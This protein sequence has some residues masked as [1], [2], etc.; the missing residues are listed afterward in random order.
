MAEMVASAVVGET[1]SRVSTLLIDKHDQKSS[2]RDDMERLE[3]AHIRMEAALE[4]SSNWPVVT[5]ISLL[6]WRNKL[7]RAAEECDIVLHRCKRRAMEDQE[8]EQK[9]RQCQFPKRI[10]HA[11]KSFFSSFAGHKSNELISSLT[12]QRFE[13]F[14]DGAG[15]FLKFMEFGS[16]R[17]PNYMPLDPLLG[18]LLAGKALQYDMSQGSQYYLAARPMHFAERGLEAGVLLRYQDHEMP[19]KNFTFGIL[20]RVSESMDLTGIVAKCLESFT[21]HFKP[22]V[23]SA[24]QELTR[25][26]TRGLYCFPFV[27]STTDPEY[28]QIHSSETRRARPNP[29]CCKGHEHKDCSRS[30]DILKLSGALPEPVIKLF[31]QRYVSVSEQRRQKPS[32]S[33]HGDRNSSEDL[34][35]LQLT[36]VFEPHASPQELPS[37]VESFAVEAID[38]KEEQVMHTNV[39]L[40]ELDE[41]LLPGVISRLCDEAAEGSAH[42]VFWRSGH[43]VAYLCVEKAGTNMERYRVT[44]WQV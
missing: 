22:I 30:T 11:T 18:H 20:L 5:D 1:L 37:G 10:A 29:L 15:E 16:I 4:T 14:A 26:N 43:G 38:G 2:E 23:E 3:M 39:G 44:Q 28:W 27:D 12:V 9:V 41:L 17:Q 42:E 21:P 24:K 25:I 7:K 8:T 31:V 35:P 36:A 40:H 34:R 33:V 19:E 32:L 13:R 6:R